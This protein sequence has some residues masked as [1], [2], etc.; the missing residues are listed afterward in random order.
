MVGKDS[1]SQLRV[2]LA[3]QQ[4][5]DVRGSLFR[6]AYDAANFDNLRAARLETLPK[7]LEVNLI[8][9]LIII[10]LKSCIPHV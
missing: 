3:E 2:E 6:I 8:L 10:S 9:F 5:V 7:D 1:A 4:A